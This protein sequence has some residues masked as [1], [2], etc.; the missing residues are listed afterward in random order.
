[1]NEEKKK[2]LIPS[3]KIIYFSDKDIITLSSGDE[4]HDGGDNEEEFP[5]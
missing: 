5:Y 2:L 3:L 1:M 4:V